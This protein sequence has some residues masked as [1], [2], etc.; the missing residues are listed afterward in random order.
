MYMFIIIGS[1]LA[2]VFT[3][4]SYINFTFR[5]SVS[6]SYC[7]LCL[8]Y[9]GYCWGYCG[10]YYWE[11]LRLLPRVP[12]ILSTKSTKRVL[13]MLWFLLGVRW[14]LLGFCGH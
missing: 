5:S 4:E 7:A 10:L 1:T 12:R 14:L 2:R 9:C 8:D 11:Y 6:R 13:R 3:G